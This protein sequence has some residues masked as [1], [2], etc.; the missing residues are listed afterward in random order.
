MERSRGTAWRGPEGISTFF[1]FNNYQRDGEEERNEARKDREQKR[2]PEGREPR[3]AESLAAEWKGE[4]STKGPK[5]E[6]LTEL[7]D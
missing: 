2:I 6:A 3:G 1:F 7:G 5:Q 4:H